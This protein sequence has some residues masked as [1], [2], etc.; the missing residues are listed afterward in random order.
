MK[1]LRPKRVRIVINFE[2]RLS[3]VEEGDGEGNVPPG[4]DSKFDLETRENPV[5]KGRLDE[6]SLLQQ[7]RELQK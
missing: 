5:R 6:G 4:K 7:T 2:V 1:S 3:L